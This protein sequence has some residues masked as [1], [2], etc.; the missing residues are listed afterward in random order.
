MGPVIPITIIRSHQNSIGTYLS[1]YSS[2]TELLKYF[3]SAPCLSAQGS[4]DQAKEVLCCDWEDLTKEPRR[5]QG[6]RSL[7]FQVAYMGVS[8]IRGTFKGIHK[9]SLKGSIRVL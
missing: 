8:E 7:G 1:P 2:G 9:G 3:A 5:G 4:L 6:L